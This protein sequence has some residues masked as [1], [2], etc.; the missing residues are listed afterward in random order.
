MYGPVGVDAAGAAIDAYQRGVVAAE[1][2]R[3]RAG[4]PRA[5]QEAEHAR[6]VESGALPLGLS[7]AGFMGARG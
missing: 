1:R 3:G 4:Q 7:E 5:M 2:Y 6:L